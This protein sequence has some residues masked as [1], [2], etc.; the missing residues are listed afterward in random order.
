MKEKYSNLRTIQQS[1]LEMMD[2]LK[3][4]DVDDRYALFEEMGMWWFDT[5]TPGDE[6]FVPDWDKVNEG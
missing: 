6:L 5:I 2:R 1:A 3:Q 4:L